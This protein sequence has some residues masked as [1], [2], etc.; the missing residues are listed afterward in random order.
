MSESAGGLLGIS[1]QFADLKLKYYGLP[2]REKMVLLVLGVFCVCVVFYYAI[3]APVTSS[4]DR[5]YER[6]QKQLQLMAWMKANES[7][8]K[9]ASRSSGK[10][11]GSRGGRSI[12]S[13][14]NATSGKYGIALKRFEPKGEDGLRVWLEN[15]P[16]DKMLQWLEVLKGSYG[17]DVANVMLE[18]QKDSGK[19]NVT[20]VLTA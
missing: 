14:V 2:P 9:K 11:G 16:F 15:V 10:S 7:A 8:A 1:Q 5:A 20:L 18:A 6:Y 12:L 19:V 4:A 13:L 3:W 17:I